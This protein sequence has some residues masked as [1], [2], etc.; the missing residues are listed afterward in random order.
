MNKDFFEKCREI[1]DKCLSDA[2]RWTRVRC[3]IMNC[4]TTRKILFSDIHS[5]SVLQNCF[6]RIYG[7]KFVIMFC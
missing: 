2:I 4:F 1:V 6:R 3:S 7:S 5:T